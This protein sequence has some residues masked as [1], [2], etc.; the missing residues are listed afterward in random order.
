[1]REQVT[2]QLEVEKRDK[3]FRAAL[4]EREQSL[5]STAPLDRARAAS[6]LRK[7]DLNV[8]SLRRALVVV[9]LQ[10]Q[11]EFIYSALEEE[12]AEVVEGGSFRDREIELFV[13]EFG[14]LDARLDQL[15][16]AVA[17]DEA[18]VIDDE[19]LA[20]LATDIPDLKVSFSH[21]SAPSPVNTSLL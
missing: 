6:G 9:T 7:L 19:Y 3:E 12:A 21:L 8:D 5:R 20:V 2:L 17:N 15:A 4:S 10:L 16:Q 11:L 1:V 18:V 14:S 13:K